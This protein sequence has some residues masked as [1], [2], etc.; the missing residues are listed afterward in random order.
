MTLPCWLARRLLRSPIDELMLPERASR[1]LPSVIR[2]FANNSRARHGARVIN[3]TT[4]RQPLMRWSKPA[5]L[6][7]AG[8]TSSMTIVRVLGVWL[9]HTS[10]NSIAKECPIVPIPKSRGN[11]RSRGTRAR[12]FDYKI[13][14]PIQVESVLTRKQQDA[15]RAI[16]TV[17]E[18][19]RE[20]S[21]IFSA[22][23]DAHFAYAVAAG[24]VRVSR[25]TETG[26]RRILAFMLPGDLFGLPHEGHYVNWAETACRCRLYRIPWQQWNQIVRRAPD[27]QSALVMLV[28]ADLWRARQRSM[29]LV[30]KSAPQKLATFL[31][32][33]AKYPEFYDGRRRR[34]ELPLTR[35]DLADYLGVA[36]ETVVRI[37]AKFEK[38]KLI[39]RLSPRLIALQ[40]MDALRRLAQRDVP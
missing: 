12:R 17:M 37:F 23:E 7:H 9:T 24:V 35:F 25:H 19:E 18:F 40:D 33:F 1:S 4:H 14:T 26:R 21:A 38:A 36:H 8:S 16:V 22:G 27:M 6:G 13:D 2:A 34:L 10:F 11:A 31:L 15:L 30:R 28:A 32:D 39:H 20:N 29:T 3:S 5:I